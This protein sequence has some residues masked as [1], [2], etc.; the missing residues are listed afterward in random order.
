MT[1]EMKHPERQAGQRWRLF[2]RG[3]LDETYAL[4]GHQVNAWSATASTGLTGCVLPDSMW[5]NSDWTM[6]L[7]SPAPQAAPSAPSQCGAPDRSGCSPL[8]GLTRKAFM[9]QP[10]IFGPKFRACFGGP[11]FGF[12]FCSKACADRFVPTLPA[13]PVTTGAKCPSCL[14]C[15]KRAPLTMN[16]CD[17]CKPAAND[18]G[19]ATKVG[20]VCRIKGVG[21]HVCDGAVATRVMRGLPVGPYCEQTYRTREE[22]IAHLTRATGTPCASPP[23][24]MVRARMGFQPVDD[25]F[26]GDVR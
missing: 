24:L 16:L 9:D 15:S 7:L 23:G 20:P 3:W 11:D 8:C 25:D 6:T 10:S 26:A 12:V 4:D 1:N 17:D 22:S 2:K 14:G 5:S 13:A 19:T 21:P 18:L